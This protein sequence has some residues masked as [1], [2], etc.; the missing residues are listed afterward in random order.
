MTANENGS[1]TVDVVIRCT[2]RDIANATNL[3]VEDAAFALNEIGLLALR[4]S[5]EDTDEVRKTMQAELDAGANS[6]PA[7]NSN[8]FVFIS[9]A[10]VERVADDRN[11]KPPCM[12]VQYVLIGN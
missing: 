7:D 4:L 12:D 9:R 2:L 10:M 11:V 6:A 5:S 3:R 1:A 8:K